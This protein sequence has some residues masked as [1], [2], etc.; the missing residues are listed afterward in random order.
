MAQNETQAQVAQAVADLAAGLNAQ[1]F[2]QGAAEGV[3]MVLAQIMDDGKHAAMIANIFAGNMTG[4]A[5]AYRHN[6][7]RTT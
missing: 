1:D 6:S 3:G 2:M 5:C 4:H 7:K